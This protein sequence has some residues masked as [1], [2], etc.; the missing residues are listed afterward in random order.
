MAV[1]EECRRKVHLQLKLKKLQEE[2]ALGFL[3]SMDA[4]LKK[5]AGLTKN[6]QLTLECAK[7]I[8]MPDIYKSK[9]QKYLDQFLI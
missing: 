6:E 8:R 5:V 7:Y 3:T 2:E 4:L 9:S 1:L